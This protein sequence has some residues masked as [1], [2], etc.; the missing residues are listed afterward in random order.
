MGST[1]NEAT[2]TTTMNVDAARGSTLPRYASAVQVGPIEPEG[3]AY[4]RLLHWTHGVEGE[5]GPGMTTLGTAPLSR[6][7]G[8][9]II[10]A[11][12]RALGI[13]PDRLVRAM[14]AVEGPD[15]QDLPTEELF[16]AFN[17]LYAAVAEVTGIPTAADR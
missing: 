5:Y 7:E 15:E 4:V 3:G 1:I 17:E 9:N 11:I 2:S 13:D 8:L 14:A 12:Q 16:E 6:D 10:R